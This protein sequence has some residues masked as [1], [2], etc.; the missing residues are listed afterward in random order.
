MALEGIKL[1]AQTFGNNGKP[2]PKT[3]RPEKVREP[4]AKKKRDP[5]PASLRKKIL[6]DANYTCEDCGDTRGNGAKLHID[7]IF[8]V[9]DG[10][11]TCEQNLQVLC[12]A[13]NLGKKRSRRTRALKDLPPPKPDPN[14]P[15]KVE[16]RKKKD[17]ELRERLPAKRSARPSPAE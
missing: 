2:M 6:H 7:H 16:W 14:T 15:E 12:E 3:F 11:R 13:C 1:P 8:P 5:I 17:A 9:A 10:G 4:K